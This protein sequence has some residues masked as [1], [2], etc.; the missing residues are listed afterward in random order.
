MKR[1]RILAA[2]GA[3]L[4]A[5]L[6]A[7]AIPA[8]AAVGSASI[9]G[10]TATLNL[11]G[12]ND[13][14]TVSVSGGLLVHGQTTGGLNSGSDWDSTTAND[15]TV[16]ANGTF[17]V[18]INGGDGNDSLTVLAKNTEI[19]AAKLIGEGG[20][21]VLTGADSNDSLAGGD[22][23]DRVVGAKGDDTMSGGAGNDTLIWNNGDGS[24]VVD[25]D[26]GNDETVINGAPTAG[27]Q[28]T[29]KPQGNRVRFDRVNLGPFFVDLTSERLTVNG[30]GGN[31]TMTADPG[32]AALTALT[33]RGDEGADTIA[34][35]DGADRIFGGDDVDTLVGGDGSDELVG[36]RANDVVSGGVGDDTLVW[37]NGDGSDK[38]DGE[39]GF[40]TVEVNGALAGDVFTIA[41]AAGDRVRF[42]RTNLVP[43]V[44]DIATSEELEVNGLDGDDQFSA[45]PGTGLAMIVNGNEGNDSLSGSEGPDALIGGSGVD[46][47]SGGAGLDVLD[48]QDGDDALNVRDGSFDLARGGA[49]TDSAQT[50]QIGVDALD[51]IE[52]VDALPGNATKATAV[53]VVTKRVRLTR[54][55]GGGYI[56]RIKVS[57]PADETDGCNGRLDLLTA[58]AV[59]LGGIRAPVVLGT[60]TYDL[61]AG[62][63]KTLRLRLPGKL[64]RIDRRGKIAARAHTVT[65]DAKGRSAEGFARIALTLPKRDR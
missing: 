2:L 16:P 1:M 41:P 26:A 18:V 27:D 50:D 65:S 14:V 9:E 63:S 37:N 5:S 62:K 12:A 59:R 21:D 52:N 23:N 61:D 4:A 36:D 19:G 45:Q 6:A 58:R 64:N 33:L 53:T 3:A 34:G 8:E 54:R 60:A 22:G 46:A 15:Q 49:G 48:G 29:I 43:F 30:L 47:L 11:D 20:D 56:A 39:D 17:T 28:F 24:D 13:N 40:D 10:E 44:L 55:N 38:N 57:C 35:G 7:T 42:D 32:L 51:S 25:G 31:E